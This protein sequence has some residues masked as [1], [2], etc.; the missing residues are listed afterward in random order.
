[1]IS[2]RR[3]VREIGVLKAVISKDVIFEKTD[4]YLSSEG[5]GQHNDGDASIVAFFSH[6]CTSLIT[7]CKQLHSRIKNARLEAISLGIPV[8]PRH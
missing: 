3:F 1:M 4:G 5:K 8:L 6:S 7:E 2:T